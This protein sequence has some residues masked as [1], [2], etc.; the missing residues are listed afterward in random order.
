M[1]ADPGDLAALRAALVNAACAVAHSCRPAAGETEQ[2]A[3]LRALLALAAE[4]ARLTGAAPVEASAAPGASQHAQADTE[5]PGATVECESRADADRVVRLLERS[6]FYAE[7]SHRC[8]D[9]L[10]SVE[11]VVG[12][13]ASQQARLESAEWD[14]T[15]LGESRYRELVRLSERYGK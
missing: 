5:S 1:T 7:R 6:G 10:A 9:T 13:L 3:A 15:P 4:H 8:V 14:A 12:I 2:E 11:E